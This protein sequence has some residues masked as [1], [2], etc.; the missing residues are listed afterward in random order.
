MSDKYTKYDVSKGRI[1]E[2]EQDLE[3]FFKKFLTGVSVKA[4][5]PYEVAAYKSPHYDDNKHRREYEVYYL[6]KTNPIDK[7][8]IIGTRG[9][10][11][12]H[13]KYLLNEM[14]RSTQLPDTIMDIT[15]HPPENIKNK[16]LHFYLRCVM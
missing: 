2:V 12:E 5:G 14:E 4:V 3:T 16:K 9:S 6:L 8:E 10:M 11:Y 1:Q 15:N 7:Q 13:I